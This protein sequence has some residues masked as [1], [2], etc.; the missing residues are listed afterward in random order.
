MKE[1]KEELVGKLCPSYYR[2]ANRRKEEA[3]ATF[4][5]NNIFERRKISFL[6]P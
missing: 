6:K 3:I 1:A 2:I 5:I 4:N